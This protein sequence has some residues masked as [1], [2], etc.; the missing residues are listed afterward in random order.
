MMSDS[1]S[2]RSFLNNMLTESRSL[3]QR[4]EDVAA[5]R[6]E[7]GDDPAARSQMRKTALVS[8]AAAGF[9]GLLLGSG[10]GRK[11]AV[12]GGLGL[13]GKVAYDAY[14]KSDAGS[15][16]ALPQA[17]PIHQITDA[18]AER[19]A[20]TLTH[21]IISAAKA[22]GHIDEPERKAIEAQMAELPESVRG[23]LTSALLNPADPAAVA[24]RAT[25]DQER[26]EIY[27]ASVLAA[28]KD[29]PDELVYMDM[30]ARALGLPADQVASIEADMARA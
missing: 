19:R 7:V 29:H 25:S 8:G 17:A 15:A 18:T 20:V 5:D 28:G 30:L 11:L 13:L 23:T 22:D 2:I 4:A 14:Q 21:A 1:T 10:T 16:A 6:L 3:A 9:M 24:A 12:V 26:R 27:A